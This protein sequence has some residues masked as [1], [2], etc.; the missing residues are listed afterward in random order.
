[1]ELLLPK[2]EQ[3]EENEIVVKKVETK[4]ENEESKKTISPEIIKPP[5]AFVDQPPSD[6]QSLLSQIT[7]STSIESIVQDNIDEGGCEKKK[8]NHAQ[9]ARYKDIFFVQFH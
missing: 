8:R 1:M 7:E 6:S 9:E 3:K 5:D 4:V 2:L